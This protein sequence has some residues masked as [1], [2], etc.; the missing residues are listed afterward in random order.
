MLKVLTISVQPEG[1]VI[2]GAA[3]LPC[4]VIDASMTS[5]AS[6]PEGL[7]RLSDVALLA[8]LGYEPELKLSDLSEPRRNPAA[9]QLWAQIA[10]AGFA[11]GNLMLLAIGVYLGERCS[12]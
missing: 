2:V 9:R 1:D 7:L 11:F 4:A 10:V 3:E 8:S 12:A 5:F 6:V